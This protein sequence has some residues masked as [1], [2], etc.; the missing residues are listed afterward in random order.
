MYESD[1]PFEVIHSYLNDAD[2]TQVMQLHVLL[3][4]V[5][6]TGQVESQIPLSTLAC[7]EKDTPFITILDHQTY[8]CK[9]GHW[10]LEHDRR[11]AVPHGLEYASVSS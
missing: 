6:A 3:L 1:R 11:L 9:D 7:S 5:E 10:Q 2:G 4:R 8:T